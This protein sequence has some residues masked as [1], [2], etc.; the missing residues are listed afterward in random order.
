MDEGA[1]HSP[2]WMDLKALCKGKVRH[3]DHILYG[4]IYCVEILE[5]ADLWRP[6]ADWGEV[7]ANG[8]R[9]LGGVMKMF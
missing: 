3:E 1:I 6:K 4:S 9:G 8:D 2:V 5:Q 7:T